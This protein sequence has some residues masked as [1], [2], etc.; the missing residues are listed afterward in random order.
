MKRATRKSILFLLS[1][2]IL[3]SCQKDQA[4]ILPTEPV[5]KQFLNVDQALW[6]FYENFELAGKE[7]GLDIDLSASEI[8]GAIADIAEDHV[9][10][11]CTYGTFIPGDVVIDSDFWNN[12]SYY[13]KEMVVF[14]ELGHCFLHRDH[15]EEELGNGACASIMRSGI[16][17]C[18]DNYNSQTRAYYLDELFEN[19]N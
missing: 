1:I 10:G 4:I 17:G 18:F 5:Q 8:T 2:L 11:Q 6:T 14:H 16:N 19:V 7:R 12:A 9:A 13:L 3:Q 15:I